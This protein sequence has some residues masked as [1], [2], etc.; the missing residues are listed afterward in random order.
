MSFVYFNLKTCVNHNQ[1]LQII[2]LIKPQ[3]LTLTLRKILM[4]IP[5]NCIENL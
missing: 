3:P 5:T 1:V 2:Y 4:V